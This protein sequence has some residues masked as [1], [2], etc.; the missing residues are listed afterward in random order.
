MRRELG[1]WPEK[2]IWKMKIW[3][4]TTTT[5]FGQSEFGE[6]V[7]SSSIRAVTCGLFYGSTEDGPICIFIYT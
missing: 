7:Y 4:L 1:G 3:E 5:E 6:S 2:A